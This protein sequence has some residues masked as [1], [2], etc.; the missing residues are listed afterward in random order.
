M[1]GVGASKTYGAAYRRAVTRQLAVRGAAGAEAAVGGHF[2]AVGQ[3]ERAAVQAEGLR[4]D[5]YL[6]DIGCG[7]GRLASALKDWPSLRYLGLDVSPQLLEHARIA[8][9]RKDWRF[10]HVTAPVVPAPDAVADMV[11]MFS[12]I[13]HL[14]ET[15]TRAYF[16]EIRRVL[17]PSG[18]AVVSFLDPTIAEHRQQIRPA[19]IEAIVTRIA[20]APNVATSVQTLRTWAAAAGL[21]VRRVE[22]PAP[23]GQSIIVLAPAR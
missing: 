8:S 15:D 13:T 9:S 19:W 18:V 11:T 23:I 4:E 21:D 1:N 5:G 2:H 22:S 20:W 6:I 16:A 12:V 17:K 14:A 3:Q 7:A 10:E